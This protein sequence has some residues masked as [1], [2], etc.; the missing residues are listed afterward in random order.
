MTETA[1][2]PDTGPE[3]DEELL[4]EAMRGA[5]TSWRNEAINEALRAYVEAKREIRRQARE[6]L[7]RMSDEG[8]FTYDALDE[9]DD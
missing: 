3:I 9:V 2:R 1:I 7:R 4:A 5:G 6:E 8:A